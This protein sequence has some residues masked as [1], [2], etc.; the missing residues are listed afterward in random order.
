MRNG[1]Q[2]PDPWALLAPSP[3]HPLG[4]KKESAIYHPINLGFVA[5]I[6]KKNLKWY[7]MSSA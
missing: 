6:A 1:R 7:L 5:E 4:L 3:P 2:S